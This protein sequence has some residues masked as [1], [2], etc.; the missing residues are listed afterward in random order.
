M[1][2]RRVVLIAARIELQRPGRVG[3]GQ[4]GVKVQ[5]LLRSRGIARSADAE[6]VAGRF[7]DAIVGLVEHAIDE[8]GKIALGRDA[9]RGEIQLQ[10]CAGGGGSHCFL[11]SN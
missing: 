3:I 10:L 2:R 6:R 9:I 1:R 4:V 11:S 8:I 5:H 7:N